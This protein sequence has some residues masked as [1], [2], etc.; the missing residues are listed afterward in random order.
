MQQIPKLCI[1]AVLT[2]ERDLLILIFENETFSI[3]FFVL[4]GWCFF[5][6]CSSMF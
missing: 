5:C 2:P 3:N 4:D 1:F 6:Q